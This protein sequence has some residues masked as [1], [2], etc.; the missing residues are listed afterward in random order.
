MPENIHLSNHPLVIHLVT[1]LRE[2]RYRGAAFRR[3]VAQ[4]GGLLLTEALAKE[5]LRD[6]KI[7]MW[8]GE[9]EFP[10]LDESSYV[11]ISILRA[12]QPMVDGVLELL[13]DASAGFLAMRRDE[14]TLQPTLYY[15][16]I[17][18]LEGKTAIV[19]DPMVATGGSLTDALH[20]VTSKHPARIFSLHILSLSEALI[21]VGGVFP[22]VN[23]FVACID[24]KLSSQGFIL[25]GL[26]DAGDRAYNTL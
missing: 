17:P 20:L 21:K 18:P 13:P 3:I 19:C 25:P 2:E 8:Q 11:V 24:E 16:R 5:E 26:G 22:D 9:R 4:L 7:T 1:K 6:R 10:S 15:D 14:K 23:F 12:A